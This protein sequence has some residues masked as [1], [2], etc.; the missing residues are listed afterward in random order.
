MERALREGSRCVTADGLRS[1]TMYCSCSML[2]LGP[3]QPSSAFRAA[4]PPAQAATGSAREKTSES[5]K[6]TEP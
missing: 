4:R 5:E 2:T 1:M 3:V 6:N